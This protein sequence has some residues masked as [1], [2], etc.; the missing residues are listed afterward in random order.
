M[1]ATTGG[2]VC[3]TGG[4]AGDFAAATGVA[5]GVGDAWATMT[6]ER[7]LV[8]EGVGVPFFFLSALVGFD[9]VG[10]GG[11]G[12]GAGGGVTMA[13]SIGDAGSTRTNSFAAGGGGVGAIPA[14]ASLCRFGETRSRYE[15]YCVSALRRVVSLKSGHPAARFNSSGGSR[16]NVPGPRVWV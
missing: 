13:T 4:A 7:V 10:E 8:G 16:V 6:G 9:G 3:A 2:V 1:A 5:T 14:A 15:A 11:G 12:T